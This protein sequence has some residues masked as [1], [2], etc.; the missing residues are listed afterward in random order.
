MTVRLAELHARAG[1]PV[2][3]GQLRTW[4]HDL[5]PTSRRAGWARPG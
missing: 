2:L 3:S 1:L 5:P 4:P